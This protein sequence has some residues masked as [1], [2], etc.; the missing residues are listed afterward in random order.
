M[1]DENFSHVKI[2]VSVNTLVSVASIL[3]SFIIHGVRTSIFN[4]ISL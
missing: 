2:A 4:N 1:D 3:F